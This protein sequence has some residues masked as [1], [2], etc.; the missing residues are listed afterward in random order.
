[1]A[2]ASAKGACANPSNSFAL[3]FVALLSISKEQLDTLGDEDLCLFNNRVRRVFDRRMAK[4]HGSKP[5]CFECG[6]P[7][8]FV[9]E[10]PKRNSYYTKGNGN[11]ANDSGGSYKK[12][13]YKRRSKK[14]SKVKNFKKFA[15][16]F[17]K[18]TKYREKAFI[19]K[20]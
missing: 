3:S 14:G 10:C 11:G 1:M 5:G 2:L 12:Y 8:H 4:K 16:S 7:G 9:A 20:F 6:D 15:K 19:A 18:E 13:D 17:H